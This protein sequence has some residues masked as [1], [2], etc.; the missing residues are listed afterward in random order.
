ME[1]KRRQKTKRKFENSKSAKKDK[2]AFV[3]S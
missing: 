2:N 3:E 1:K